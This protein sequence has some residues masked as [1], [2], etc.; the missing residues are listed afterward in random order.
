MS[1][2]RPLGETTAPTKSLER[3]QARSGYRLFQAIDG[4][5]VAIPEDV[6]ARVFEF[7]RQSDPAECCG[8]LVGTIC[9]DTHGRHVVIRGAILDTGAKAET[10]AIETTGESEF[11]TK[12]L[13][14]RLFPDAT[15]VGWF[16]SHVRVGAVFS[17]TDRRN[18]TSWGRNALGLVVD[19]WHATAINVYRGPDSELLSAVT[20]PA[21]TTTRPSGSCSSAATTPPP[22]VRPRPRPTWL[23]R[24]LTGVFCALALLLGV[25]ITKRLRRYEDRV[26]LLARREEE[27]GERLDRLEVGRIMQAPSDC[28]ARMPT[29]GTPFVREVLPG[30]R[31]SAPPSSPRRPAT[32]RRSR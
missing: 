19:P 13:A 22:S 11:E 6:I 8:Q 18:Q 30:P 32:T 21:T 3:M 15:S 4:F 1:T 10:Y 2:F 24:S 20:A 9:D 17:Q 31:V 16:H 23:R 12:A 28:A 14:R 5:E 26:V 7:A 27:L 25:V 29:A